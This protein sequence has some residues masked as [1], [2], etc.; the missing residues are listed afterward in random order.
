MF[1]LSL[2]KGAE[3]AINADLVSILTCVRDCIT[4]TKKNAYVNVF[5]SGAEPN[6]REIKRRGA[7]TSL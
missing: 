6:Y 7:E 3:T 4:E 1:S 2:T 5:T